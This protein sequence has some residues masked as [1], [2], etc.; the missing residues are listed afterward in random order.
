MYWTC[1]PS[2]GTKG[3]GDATVAGTPG[4]A[5]AARGFATPTSPAGITGHA[6]ILAAG[7]RPLADGG[8]AGNHSRTGCSACLHALSAC[9]GCI[10]GS[11]GR[12]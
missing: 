9:R 6:V 12:T 10:R 2:A 4:L 5:A 1:S 11:S 8:T 7:T 3:R